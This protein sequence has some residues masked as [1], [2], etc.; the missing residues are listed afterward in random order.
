MV[1]CCSH[2]SFALLIGFFLENLDREIMPFVGTVISIRWH[3]FLRSIYIVFS[4]MVDEPMR[5]KA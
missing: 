4:S 2:C 1:R 3:T 5:P